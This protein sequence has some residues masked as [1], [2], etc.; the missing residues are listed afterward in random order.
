MAPQTDSL[1]VYRELAD[2]YDRLGQMAMRDRFLILAADAALQAGQP[3]LA[4]QL[5]QR[6]LQGSRH[7]MLRSYASFA[8]ASAAPDVQTYLRD[9]RVNY[10][11]EVAREMLLELQPHEEPPSPERAIPP[12][13]PLIDMHGHPASARPWQPQGRAEPYPL[14]DDVE[15]TPPPTKPLA[16]PRPYGGAP[17]HVIQP[18]PAEPALPVAAPLPVATPVPRRPRE[19]GPKNPAG[20]L[21]VGL[22]G[23]VFLAALAAAAFTFARPFLR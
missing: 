18:A 9:L 19:R 8:E 3:A 16:Q 2:H 12:T 13:A 4:E 7:H 21:S 23:L 5:R 15:H 22:G 10:P 1:S 20:W 6:L 14:R 11:M 17:R